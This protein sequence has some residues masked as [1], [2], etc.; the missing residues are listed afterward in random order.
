MT[1]SAETFSVETNVTK[2][3]F[4]NHQGITGTLAVVNIGPR[5][6][7]GVRQ[8]GRMNYMRRDMWDTRPV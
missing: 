7:P 4:G 8:D 1:V 6:R 2:V 5:M 3:V